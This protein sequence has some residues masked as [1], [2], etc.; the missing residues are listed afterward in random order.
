MVFMGS[1]IH[2]H[3]VPEPRFWHL[4]E[5]IGTP[6]QNFGMSKHVTLLNPLEDNLPMIL[7][8]FEVSIT[9]SLVFNGLQIHVHDITQPRFWHFFKFIGTPNLNFGMS[10]HVT[11]LNRLEDTL[12]I[13]LSHISGLVKS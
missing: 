3:D 8:I 10:E 6:D 2:V 4:F 13:I 9:I 1:R 11:L 7:I 5:V 12:P